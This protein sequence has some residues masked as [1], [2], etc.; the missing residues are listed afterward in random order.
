[1]KNELDVCVCVGVCMCVFNPIQQ[2]TN[3]KWIQLNKKPGLQIIKWKIGKDI[4]WTGKLVILQ[5]PAWRHVTTF[6]STK[7][8]VVKVSESGHLQCAEAWEGF[9]ARG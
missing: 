2:Q 8:A 4:Y 6:S 1:M 5:M 3:S 9:K 7:I